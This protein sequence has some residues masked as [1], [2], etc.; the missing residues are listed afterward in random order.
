MDRVKKTA[1]VLG[2]TPPHVEL[3]NKLKGRGY[4]VVLVDY[5]EN[6]PAAEFSDLH[7][8]I[9]TLDE[10]K[11][12]ELAR[13][14]SAELVLAVCVD[15]A[16]V[17]AA[18]VSERLELETLWD[19]SRLRKMANKVTMKE[20]LLG[21]GIQTARYH[22]A[23]EESDLAVVDLAFPVVVKPA[24]SNGSKGVR[25]VSSNAELSSAF[26][27]AKDF[28][29]VGVVLVEEFLTGVEF[30]ADFF[31]WEGS[32]INLGV[33]KKIRLPVSG[34]EVLGALGSISPSQLKESSF[35]ELEGIANLL[36]QDLRVTY[37]PLL[38]QFILVEGKVV[39][40]EFSLR[41]GGGMSVESVKLRSGV[42]VTEKVLNC[43]LGEPTDI[44]PVVVEKVILT[45]NLFG[46]EGRFGTIHGLEELARD[47]IIDS[48]YRLKQRGD[49]VGVSFASQD[50]IASLIIVAGTLEEAALRTRLVFERVRVLDFLGQEM[51]Q[52]GRRFVPELGVVGLD[53]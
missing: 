46:F 45:W 41:L 53:S 51:L 16:N 36:A 20:I 39:V 19:A 23:S 32:V 11:V 4:F 28:S 27:C 13:D 12:Y 40:L 22:I 18:V 24:D 1:V 31:I 17:T 6:P 47:G 35:S 38:V 34:D 29:R 43:L 2:G 49:R 30:S 9:S 7:V 21:A 33:K 3:I 25:K 50:R 10:Q 42:D 15:Q 26:T 44:S 52:S 37:S 48:F 8:R 14:F 5:L